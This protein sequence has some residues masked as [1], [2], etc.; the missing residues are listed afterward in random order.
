MILK[1]LTLTNFGIYKGEHKVELT[2][3]VK[4]PIILFGAYNGS[5]KTTFLDA[6]QLVLYGKSAKTSGRAKIPYEEYLKLMINRDVPTKIGAGLSLTFTTLRNGKTETIEV[7]RTWAES[8]NY[9][10][11]HCEVK[12]NGIFEPVTSERWGEFVEEFMPSEISELFFFDG[13]KIEG[14]ADPSRSAN[15]I[16]SGIYSLLGI[17][18]IESLLKSLTQIERRRAG[19]ITKQSNSVSLENEERIAKELSKNFIKIDQE[20]ALLRAELDQVKKE[21]GILEDEMK[22]SGANL[23]ENRHKL[24]E[25][26]SVLSEKRKFIQNELTELSSSRAPLLLVEDMLLEIRK[27]QENA[28]GHTIKSVEL[29]KTEVELAKE[30]CRNNEQLSVIKNF[31]ERIVFLNEEVKKSSLNIDPASIPT[32]S[33]LK[34]LKAILKEKIEES[35]LIEAEIDAT[36]K[37]LIAVPSEDKIKDIVLKL[38]KTEAEK[39]RLKTKIET[40]DEILSEVVMNQEKISKEISAKLSAIAEQETEAIV[41]QRILK[42]AQ[43]SKETL[44]KFREQLIQNHLTNLGQEIT[45]CFKNLQRKAKF[46]LFFEINPNNFSLVVKKISGH[47]VSAKTLSAGERQLLAVAILWALARSSGKVLPTVIDTPLGRL[48]MPHRQKLLSNY[49]PKASNQVLIFS[50]DAEISNEQYSALRQYISKEYTINYD[51]VT[52]S[53]S[54]TENYFSNQISKMEVALND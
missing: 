39:I 28:S 14:L 52:E 18:S 40:L 53:S 34:E 47:E 42:H 6:L 31:E 25:K 17:N 8:G 11:E 43:K 1:E 22:S 10:K 36:N 51:E 20:R 29:L 50:T 12:R 3:S 2:P 4:K 23:F 44:I 46:N 15:F 37:N 49:F 5:G 24:Q 27:T 41:S 21:V 33:E 16:K 45:N 35:E 48:D 7:T 54:F 30:K 38:N 13:E 9:I 26:L 32:K 19:E